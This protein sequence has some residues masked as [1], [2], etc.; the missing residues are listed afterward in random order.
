L[1]AAAF[2]DIAVRAAAEAGFANYDPDACLINRY[3]P[4][5][6]SVFTR[7][8]TRRMPG[9]RSSPSRSAYLLYS[10]GAANTV[11]ILRAACT[12]KAVTSRCGAVPHALSITASRRSR[13]AS[14]R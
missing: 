8:V 14:I 5:P 9:L 2:L 10:C 11:P 3:I 7:T 13:M 1:C 4:V 12:S 6:N